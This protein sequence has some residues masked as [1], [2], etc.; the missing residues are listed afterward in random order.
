MQKVARKKTKNNTDTQPPRVLDNRGGGK[1]GDFLKRAITPGAQVRAVSAYFSIHAHRALKDQLEDAQEF[2][3]LFGDPKSVAELGEHSE[4]KPYRITEGGISPHFDMELK[5]LAKSCAEW[6]KKES[7]AVRT[8]KSGFLHGKLYIA[9]N[10]DG[11]D[12][13]V[14]GSSNFTARGLGFSPDGGNW[15]LNTV[16]DDKTR[17]ALEKWF[18]DLWNSG[19]VRDVKTAMQETLNR[20]GRDESPEFVYYLTLYR[21][22]KDQL[23]AAEKNDENLRLGESEIWKTLYQFQKDAVSGVIDRLVRHGV[24]ILADSVGLGKTYTSLAVIKYYQ[25]QRI[26]VLCP[27]RLE[28]NWKRFRF[29][30]DTHNPLREDQFD[31]LVRAHTDLGLK[32]AKVDWGSFDLII[33]DESHNFRNH[34]GMRYQE[35]NAALQKSGAK[36]L[37]L[38]ATPINTALTDLRNQILLG[39]GDSAFHKALG[40]NSVRRAIVLAQREFAKWER[41]QRGKEPDKRD[42]DELMERIGGVFLK[43]MDAVTVARSRHHI[44]DFYAKHTDGGLLDFPKVAAPE[45]LNPA[46]DSKG[47]LSYAGIHAQIGA[48]GLSIY[49]PSEYLRG[50]EKPTGLFLQTDREGNLIKMMR[51]NLLKRLESSAYAFH[52]TL[53]RTINKIRNAENTIE[54]YKKD[55]SRARLLEQLDTE[56]DEDPDDDEFIIGKKH[57][58]RLSELRVDDWLPKLREDRA[59]LEAVLEQAGHVTPA[60]DAKL[61]KLKEVL[62]RKINNPTQNKD[63]KENRKV[64]VFTSF[65]D[66]AGYLYDELADDGEFG[67]V[68]MAKLVGAGGIQTN[69]GDI[70]PDYLNILRHFSPGKTAVPDSQQIDI[71]IATDCIS[72]GQNLQDCDYVVNYDIHWNPVRIV[73]RFGRIDRIGSPAGE[74]KMTNFWPD[75]D[76]NKYLSLKERVEA[77]MAL[78]A[79]GGA[80]DMVG[81]TTKTA[82]RALEF[83]N[84]QLTELRERALSADELDGVAVTNF[85]LADFLSELRAYLL[86]YKEKLD[87]TPDGVCAVVPADPAIGAYPGVIFCLCRKKDEDGDNDGGDEQHKRDNRLH[88]YYLVYVR[89]SKDGKPKVAFT[90]ANIRKS[91]RLFGNACRGQKKAIGKL[92]AAFDADISTETGEGMAKYNDM[93]VAAVQNIVAEATDRA[94]NEL[95][96]D[97][98]GL[99]NIG[100][101]EQTPEDFELSSWL[102]IRG[103]GK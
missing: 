9:N 31:Y 12:A 101:Y 29:Y 73:Q 83:R 59:K 72:E 84:W 44:K 15:E 11:G 3:F 21:L 52:K 5:P 35:L 2:Q 41:E 65:A 75:I 50:E 39:A 88:P 77:R 86:S 64:L 71:L 67:K 10:K 47:E 85:T 76:L 48:F 36:V 27:K 102:V 100:G 1:V 30:A 81:T 66:T 58:Y 49:S 19:N 46:T 90:Y 89:E 40:I 7:V 56:P 25:N 70:R 38:S 87:N 26:L 24:C 51:V 63:G 103:E 32:K 82:K 78:V 68:R 60:R 93:L 34:A 54:A 22:F 53:G 57:P 13:A 95:A 74:V 23:E 96:Q 99:L 55:K 92:C 17:A 18:D 20:L 33:I 45:T 6:L 42:K 43:L 80:G 69:C 94:V 4:Q 97:R 16:A 62:R 91:L 61:A 37:M 14:S 79:I 8:L 28:E 98:G